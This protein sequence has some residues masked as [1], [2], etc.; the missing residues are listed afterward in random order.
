[1]LALASVL[2]AVLLS[3]ILATYHAHPLWHLVSTPW[4]LL[5]M[6][7]LLALSRCL[8]KGSGGLGVTSGYAASMAFCTFWFDPALS[9]ASGLPAIGNA[10]GNQVL[11]AL[12]LLSVA[13]SASPGSLQG[14]VDHPEGY[15]WRAFAVAALVA[16]LAIIPHVVQLMAIVFLLVGGA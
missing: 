6:V 13:V 8:T 10:S 7:P 11:V 9:L 1:M 3:Q 5:R 16:L 2:G 14:V 15:L 12:S 4:Y